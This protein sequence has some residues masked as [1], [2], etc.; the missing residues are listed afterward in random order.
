VSRELYVYFRVQ[1]AHWREAMKAVMAWQRHL[2]AVH[3]NLGARTLRRPDARDGSVTLMETY[4]G[5][6]ITDQS[7]QAEIARGSPA[8][9]PWLIG[10]RHVEHFDALD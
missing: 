8:L 3:P 1:Q 5:A 6:A 4:T 9:Q 10:E 7:L 2:R